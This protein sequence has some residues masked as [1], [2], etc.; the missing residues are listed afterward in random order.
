MPPIAIS[1][2]IPVYNEELNL[3]DL[4]ARVG[5]AMLPSGFSFELICVDDGSRDG[6]ARVLA[7]AITG[8]TPGIDVEGLG[9][10]RLRG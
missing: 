10:E 6:S 3:P 1:I 5:E 8:R 7:D 4:V 2:V 9:V